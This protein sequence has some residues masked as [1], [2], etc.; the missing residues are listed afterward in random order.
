MAY[1]CVM[2]NDG[3]GPKPKGDVLDIFV[4]LNEFYDCIFVP[5]IYFY[6]QYNFPNLSDDADIDKFYKFIDDIRISGKNL[7][8][9]FS[10][11][12]T[13]IITNVEN[14]IK[15]H[16]FEYLNKFVNESF[17][18]EHNELLDSLA[19][20]QRT[21]KKNELKSELAQ[22]KR[23]LIEN[24]NLSAEKY[25]EWINI[26]RPIILPNTNESSYEH[27]IKVNP[28]NYLKYMIVM[29]QLLE[30]NQLKC[31][32]FFPLRTDIVP[33]H[34]TLDTK[35]LT[36]LFMTEDKNKYLLNIDKYK[37]E[38]W[39]HVFNMKN[40]IF[41]KKNHIFDYQITTDGYNISIRFLH[42]SYVEGE[43]EDSMD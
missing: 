25:R 19:G 9:I 5:W 2:K 30:K 8:Q 22:V 42:N 17:K 16:F 20:K 36:E 4:E 40:K 26:N 6:E 12:C 39:D 21:D 32:Q 18:N 31:F 3:R 13:Q 15:E 10:Y 33:K 1:K 24:T 43:T 29:N 38:I 14:N 28:Q 11:N 27:D 35:A 37:S 7:S 41:R 34:I 23:D